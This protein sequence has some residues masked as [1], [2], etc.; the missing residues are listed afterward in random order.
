MTLIALTLNHG[1]P[2]MMG[3]LL[4][5]SKQSTGDME[6]PTFVNGTG[7]LFFNKENRPVGLSQKLYVINDRLCVGVGG[8]KDQMRTFLKRLKALY[9]DHNF[10]DKDLFDYVEKYPQEDRTGLFAIVLKSQIV[11]GEIEFSA[12]C[13]GE[14]YVLENKWYQKI[15]SAGS[16]ASQFI[17]FTQTNPKFGT[18]LEG[19]EALLYMNQS[20]IAYWLGQ[21]VS[22]GES[23][24]N[25]WG[26]GYEMITFKDGRF[27]K[28]DE[29][30]VVLLTGE[31]GTGI[32]Y[33][34]APFS[35]MLVNYQNDVLVIRTILHNEEKVFFARSIV[36]DREEIEINYR[37]PKYEVLMII[38][39][40]TDVDTNIEY[41]PC[42]IRP[43]NIN[44]RGKSPII[45]E[46]VNGRLQ[47]GTHPKTDEYILEKVLRS[48]RAA[49][50]Q[51]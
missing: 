38:Y 3:D 23:L 21:E 33:Q 14:M 11:N 1:Y 47:M 27:I 24:S 29:Y 31:F 51:H 43:R 18:D 17:D 32:K 4:I 35:T 7:K 8:R 30:T 9:G 45:F 37:E 15:I 44:E 25:L 42:V 19:T 10:D 36:D 50:T 16:G 46:R 5:S 34:P 39:I 49:S 26:A 12:R 2:I 22:R 48:K 6:L 41:T 20:L 40:L 13:L 28:L